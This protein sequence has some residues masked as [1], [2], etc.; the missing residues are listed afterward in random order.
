MP[1]KTN[2]KISY[3]ESF[4]FIEKLSQIIGSNKTFDL[5]MDNLYKNQNLLTSN[6]MLPLYNEEYAGRIENH[7]VIENVGPYKINHFTAFI[8]RYLKAQPSSASILDI[9]CGSGDLL[10]SLATLGYTVHGVDFNHFA[11]AQANQ[12]LSKE[13]IPNTPSFEVRNALEIEGKYNTIL[14]SDVVEHLCMDELEILF[15][16]CKELLLEGG[17]LIIHT[18]NGRATRYSSEYR[19]IYT[20]LSSVRNFIKPPT[21]DIENLKHAFFTQQ[22]INVMGPSQIRSI[23]SKCGF[24]K[25]EFTFRPENKWYDKLK[26]NSILSSDMGI[27]CRV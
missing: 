15:K 2:R 27:I 7:H 10:L 5:I 8:Y 23:L 4:D 18:P 9:G 20:I 11:I 22:H 14:L 25:L 1:N 16:K 26:I 13:T 21:R 24:D 6:D 19:F 17:E 12:K 3:F